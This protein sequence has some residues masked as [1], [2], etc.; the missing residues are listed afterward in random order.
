ETD[1]RAIHPTP[2]IA[3][4]G[5]LPDARH[6]VG[7]AFRRPGLAVALV[8]ETTGE[9]GG[10]AY[11]KIIPGGTRGPPPRYDGAKIRAAN[12]LVLALARAQ[13]LQSAT[14]VSDGGLVTSLVEG[15]VSGPEPLGFVGQVA[16]PKLYPQDILFG[17][18][19]G[20]FVVSFFHEQAA[21]VMDV[22]KKHAGVP[23][24][25]IGTTGGEAFTLR[26]GPRRLEL[27]VPISELAQAW[28]D[29]FRRIEE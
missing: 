7:Q 12:A 14:D 25:V 3:M 18:E 19:P 2:M 24:Q 15:C 6:R 10:A 11:L 16:A 28:R 1:G 17:E 9:L 8:G 5:L 26:L 4:V 23:F 22:V 27:D 29:G 20:R 13:L 21:H